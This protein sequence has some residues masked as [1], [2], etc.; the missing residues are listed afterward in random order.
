MQLVGFSVDIPS[1]VHHGR[2]GRIRDI[3]KPYIIVFTIIV[4]SGHRFIR[5]LKPVRSDKGRLSQERF[6]IDSVLLRAILLIKS[7]Q[8]GT[9]L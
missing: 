6:H 7:P 4:S 9:H 1:R 8:N 3:H 5:V 2:I